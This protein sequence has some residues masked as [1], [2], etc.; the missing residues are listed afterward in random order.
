MLPLGSTGSPPSSGWWLTISTYFLSLCS[1]QCF[2]QP[3]AGTL[4]APFSPDHDLP[5]V[6]LDYEVAL[7]MTENGEKE[8]DHSAM[9]CRQSGDLSWQDLS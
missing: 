6:A 3:A 4:P 8:S 7:V 2:Q 5:R 9:P 1:H